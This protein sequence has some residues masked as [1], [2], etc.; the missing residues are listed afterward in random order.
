MFKQK[1]T[2][3]EDTFWYKSLG[4]TMGSV[5]LFLFEGAQIII[6]SLAIIIPVRYFLIQPFLVRGASMEPTFYDHE[7]L[8][9]DEISYRLREPKRGDVVVF[10]YPMNPSEFFIK[11]VIGLP[12]ETVQIEGGMVTVFNDEFPLG[13]V[14][15]EP[16]L[17]SETTVGTRKAELNP[18]EYFMLGDNRD[19]SLDS[20]TFGP[21]RRDFVVGRVWFRGFP[22]NRVSGFPFSEYNI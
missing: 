20:R 14:L 21:V 13:R 2:Q 4:P 7:Y 15:D 9:I 11:R 1:G 17:G 10:R 22:F 6:I 19:H 5:V 18:N 12:G 8:I 3:P 16:Y